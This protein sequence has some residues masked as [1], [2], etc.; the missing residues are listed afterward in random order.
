M[1][2]ESLQFPPP[3]NGFL[4][5]IPLDLEFPESLVQDLD[6]DDNDFDFE[7]DD[8]ILS[9]DS[10][11]DF[12]DNGFPSSWLDSGNSDRSISNPVVR[13]KGA[14]KYDGLRSGVLEAECRPTALDHG[15]SSEVAFKSENF[16]SS[17]ESGCFSAGS[18]SAAFG[19]GLQ[20][21]ALNNSSYSE[22]LSYNE[23][24]QWPIHSA[25]SG[26]PTGGESHRVVVKRKREKSENLT[27][28]SEVKLHRT[29]CCK[30]GDCSTVLRPVNEEEDKR[31]ARL[32]RNRESAQLSRQRK[33]HYVEELESKVKS[34]SSTIT[35]LN[36]RIACI[37]AEN[38][39]LR[40][41]LVSSCPQP[42]AYPPPH[43][44]PVGFPWVPYPSYP[45]NPQSGIAFVP[46]SQLPVVPIP[47]LKM[48][49]PASAPKVKKPSSKA[50]SNESA[51]K[52]G[53]A[54]KKVASVTFICFLISLMYF[55]DLYSVLN[56]TYGGHSDNVRSRF[57]YVDSEFGSNLKETDGT[58]FGYVNGIESERYGTWRTGESRL[59]PWAPDV[60]CS[61]LPFYGS[62]SEK[63]M[64]YLDTRPKDAFGNNDGLADVETENT[65]LANIKD[66]RSTFPVPLTG[67][68]IK[69][70]SN[71]DRGPAERQIGLA[72]GSGDHFVEDHH[73]SSVY[74]GP[75]KK[76]FHEGIAGP[77]IRSGMCTE[78]FRFE[79]TSTAKDHTT[80]IPSGSS[81]ARNSS[82]HHGANR[83]SSDMIRNRRFLYAAA[84]PLAGKTLHSTTSDYSRNATGT[85]EGTFADNSEVFSSMV[86]SV[87]LD[88]RETGDSSNVL[89]S[90]KSLSRILVVVLVDSVKYV[91]FSCT[92]PFKGSSPRL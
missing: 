17:P 3:N 2:S 57:D 68:E 27:F 92:L 78:V 30:G 64:K 85:K 74:D 66:V 82:E 55:G 65:S 81:E 6:C 86:V 56:F 7:L 60:N 32:M 46:A 4:S 49:Q 77:F 91:T 87:L 70:I 35:E 88:P 31:K 43:M 90:P 20:K 73:T 37:T 14:G 25:E 11:L 10:D 5:D 84:I 26:S 76:W 44:G 71:F 45:L 58:N 39:S 12:L 9:P 36:N 42:N 1:E 47:K 72:S 62:D 34:M 13:G 89:P 29:D 41:Q 23:R 40:Q 19:D 28:S 51:K 33:K 16:L 67:N 18:I 50:M 48:Q 61:S 53:K 59:D 63:S 38:A 83:T 15:G 8:L 69:R 75:L 79:V 54:T 21:E 24:N 22:E 80:I 52:S